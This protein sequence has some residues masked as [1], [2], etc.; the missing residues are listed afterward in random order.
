MTRP[1]KTKEIK[2]DAAQIQDGA[3]ELEGKFIA[4]QIATMRKYESGA[5]EKAGHELKKAEEN[6]TTV[7]E[8]LAKVHKQCKRGGFTAFKE[9]YCPNYER[10]QIYQILAIGN[11]K[12]TPEDERERA[13]TGMAK[14]RA[15]RESVTN[16]NVTDS[17]PP[18]QRT[19]FE[20]PPIGEDQANSASE[21]SMDIKS[22]PRG[23]P[24][25]RPPVDDDADTVLTEE[26]ER[27]I[28]LFGSKNA[29]ELAHQTVI[30]LK[31][32]VFSQ[33]LIEEL[34]HAA[35]S[36]SAAWDE[37]FAALKTMESQT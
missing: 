35:V 21:A 23:L 29:V 24:I 16:A 36:A 27:D 14:T 17:S 34:S 8:R 9:K 26:A 3:L 12:K 10:T 20:P 31:G 5:A 30:D 15:A 7:A 11:H 13:R 2:F 22:L 18:Y 28:F 37:V 33:S 19:E 6:R 1:K 4:A 25:S 32:K